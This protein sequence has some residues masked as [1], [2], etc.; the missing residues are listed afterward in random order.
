MT[1][2]FLGATAVTIVAGVVLTQSGT[3][4]ADRYGVGG[5]IVGATVL[6]LASAL[7]EIATGITAARLG[8]NQL[9]MGDI[10][11]EA[12]LG[13]SGLMRYR[14]PPEP[15]LLPEEQGRTAGAQLKRPGFHVGSITWKPRS[16]GRLAEC[17]ARAALASPRPHL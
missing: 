10:R 13:P 5:F 1:A 11:Q 16:P 9:V 3:L 7:P 17:G 15:S 6:A 8:D 14:R 12:R 2:I 4:L